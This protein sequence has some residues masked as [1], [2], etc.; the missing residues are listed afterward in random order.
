M[1]SLIK[2]LTVIQRFLF[3]RMGRSTRCSIEVLPKISCCISRCV[4]FKS[5]QFVQSRGS[6]KQMFVSLKQCETS[7]FSPPTF[8][9]S[10]PTYHNFQSRI[11]KLPSLGSAMAGHYKEKFVA[12]NRKAPM[13]RAIRTDQSDRDMSALT[14]SLFHFASYFWLFRVGREIEAL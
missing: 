11:V 10:R 12:T 4:W 13:R 2:G 7:A 14:I 3:I 6:M 8:L 1:S 5:V 9:L